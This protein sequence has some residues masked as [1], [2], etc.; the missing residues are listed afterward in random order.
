MVVSISITEPVSYRHCRR[1]CGKAGSQI[2]GRV[3]T[4]VVGILYSD[5]EFNPIKNG[6]KHYYMTWKIRESA[7]VPIS[8]RIDSIK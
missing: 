3:F 5:E 1:P 2:S 6:Y 4:G 8:F 7:A